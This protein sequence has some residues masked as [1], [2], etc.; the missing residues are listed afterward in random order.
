MCESKTGDSAMYQ[1]FWKLNSHLLY[2]YRISS[3]AD[4]Q[5]TVA[6]VSSPAGIVV[7]GYIYTNTFDYPIL[8][9]ITLTCMVYPTPSSSIT[10]QWNTTRCYTNSKFTGSNPQCFPHG[11]TTQSVTGNDLIAHDA[12][13]VTCTAK[14]SGSNYTSDPFSLRISGE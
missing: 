10:Y 2:W 5:F 4:S 14:I 8:S 12:G 3:G 7:N 13:N 6:I 11:Q 1:I 9:S